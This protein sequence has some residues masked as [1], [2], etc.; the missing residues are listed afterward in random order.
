MRIPSPLDIGPLDERGIRHVRAL[1]DAATEADGVAPLSEQTLLTLATDSPD[2]THVLARDK[3]GRV[4]G[5]AQID[6]G[7][8]EASAEIVVH[9]DRR[10]RGTGRML[11]KV[12]TRDATLPSRSGQPGD[13]RKGLRVWAHGDLPAARGLAAAAGLTVVRELLLLERPLDADAPAPALP[14][15]TVLRPL[16]PD[17]D[18]P[19]WVELNAAAFATHPEQGRLTVDDLTA[20]RAEDWFDPD[21]LKILWRTPS[22]ADPGS[23]GEALGYIWTKVHAGQPI[24]NFEGEVYVVGVAPS[25]RGRG[26]GRV[27]LDAG[28]SRLA[29]LGVRVVVLYV[30]GDNTAAVRLYERSGFTRRAVDVQYGVP[31]GGH[32]D[33]ERVVR[34]R[35]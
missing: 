3:D 31:A 16:D 5:Y 18:A 17:T 24:E 6:R 25:A 22:P 9:P 27:L 10:R 7:G 33:V 34:T 20:R 26:L 28:F 30:D 32:E 15:G 29:S 2:L 11:L 14:E 13:A 12:A 21:G 35:R 19:A 8:A 23:P 4:L 1:A